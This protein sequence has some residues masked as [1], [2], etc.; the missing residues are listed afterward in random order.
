MAKPAT[1]GRDTTTFSFVFSFFNHA[2]EIFNGK[3]IYSASGGNI[4]VSRG[5]SWSDKDTVLYTAPVQ[6]WFI[7]AL[8]SVRLDT[9]QEYYGNRCIM[10]T[11]GDEYFISITDHSITKTTFL[12][13]YYHKQVEQAVNLLNGVIPEKYRIQYVGPDTKQDCK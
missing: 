10:I 8:L 11:S 9:L 2:E 4:I 1:K 6:R 12:H 7:S 3:M 13:H 5:S